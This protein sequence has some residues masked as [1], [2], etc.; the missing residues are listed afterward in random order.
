MVSLSYIITIIILIILILL[1]FIVEY[2]KS[3]YIWGKW[4]KLKPFIGWSIKKELLLIFG[5]IIIYFILKSLK[6]DI[7]ILKNKEQTLPYILLILIIV[8]VAKS[9]WIRTYKKNLKK[10]LSTTKK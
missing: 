2:T 4:F 3:K 5:I 8:I 6:L 10:E 9:I 1:F 7:S